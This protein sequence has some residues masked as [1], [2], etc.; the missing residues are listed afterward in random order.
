MPR[1]SLQESI[2]T[3]RR[4]STI[5]LRYNLYKSDFLLINV[6]HN[7]SIYALECLDILS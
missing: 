3:L 1:D 5:T 6:I 7:H 4:R 2:H